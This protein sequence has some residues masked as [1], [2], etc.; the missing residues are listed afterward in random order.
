MNKITIRSCLF[1]L[2][3]GM[4]LVVSGCGYRC[5]RWDYRLAYRQVCKSYS[6]NGHCSFWSS[7]SYMERY[8]VKWIKDPGSKKRS[9]Y[10][11]PPGKVIRKAGESHFPKNANNPTEGENFLLTQL[12][13]FVCELLKSDDI[14]KTLASM[15]KYTAYK[16]DYNCTDIIDNEPIYQSSC[17]HDSCNGEFITKNLAGA[18]NL[19]QFKYG[20]NQ[21]WVKPAHK[22][23]WPFTEDELADWLSS[24]GLDVW[25]SSYGRIAG[26]ADFNSS[27]GHRY[28]TVY[29][30]FSIKEYPRQK[31]YRNKYDSAPFDS[32]DVIEVRWHHQNPSK[33]ETAFC[34]DGGNK[35][36][37]KHFDA[38]PKKT[39]TQ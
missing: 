16:Y 6:S 10:K 35:W 28:S 38:Y 34:K 11:I 26:G 13:P 30:K 23:S 9:S 24:L 29:Y 31:C 1:V 18:F 3:A 7:E 22:N 15:G 25:R 2:I 19:Q 39:Q 12:T 33:A 14:N 36:Y 5:E 37:Q 4:F 20:R 27:T 32:S 17:T 8:C 21:F